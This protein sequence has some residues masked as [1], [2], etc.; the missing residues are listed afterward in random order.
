[1]RITEDLPSKSPCSK[2]MLTRNVHDIVISTHKKF[3]SP[4]PACMTLY[5]C[6][7]SRQEAPIA[8]MVISSR[9]G[10]LSGE[11]VG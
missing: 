4:A 2:I 10:V 6:S 11:K 3:D 5:P 7:L 9:F 1:M 8:I